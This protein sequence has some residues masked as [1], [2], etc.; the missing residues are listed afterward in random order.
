[1]KGR[2]S[3]NPRILG[4]HLI[5]ECCVLYSLSSVDHK[6]LQRA[7]SQRQPDIQVEDALQSIQ[8]PACMAFICAIMYAW[9]ALGMLRAT[10]EAYIGLEDRQIRRN[11][12]LTSV[13]QI[14]C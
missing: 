1:V 14:K 5:F 12:M 6:D 4:L 8:D 2:H 7:H 3:Y 10:L 13:P 9:T 11:I